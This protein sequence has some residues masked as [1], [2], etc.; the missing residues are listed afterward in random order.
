MLLK[1]GEYN[2]FALFGNV[3]F[4][5]AGA[6]RLSGG[7]GGSHRLGLPG[8]GRLSWAIRGGVA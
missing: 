2:R 6:A 8:G 5:Q 4:G 3:F 1:L 7:D